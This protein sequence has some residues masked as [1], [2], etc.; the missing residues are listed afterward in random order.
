M[1][2]PVKP[3]QP[4][5]LDAKYSASHTEETLIFQRLLLNEDLE[6][7][8]IYQGDPAPAVKDC[9]YKNSLFTL[10]TLLDAVPAGVSPEDIVIS[11]ERPRYVD[12]LDI[13]LLAKRPTDPKALKKAYV[14]DVQAFREAEI[15]YE[16]DLIEYQKWRLKQ[17]LQKKEQEVA[18]LKK[19]LEKA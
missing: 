15:Q 13:K 1:K 8:E 3:I 5:H 18:E 7:E 12:Y 11:L 14:K 6:N 9:E 16:K 10:Q 19:K 4:F 2:E 17:D